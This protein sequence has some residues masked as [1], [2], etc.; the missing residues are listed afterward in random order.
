M[1]AITL[2]ASLSWTRAVKLQPWRRAKIKAKLKTT[3]ALHKGR[4]QMA[5]ELLHP[6]GLCAWPFGVTG[7]GEYFQDE[8]KLKGASHNECCFSCLANKAD[9]SYND[10]KAGAK[11]RTTVVK[12]TGACPPK[13]LISTVPGVVGEYWHYELFHILC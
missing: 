5:G 7:D 11:W 12:H 2:E 4:V 6:D 8:Y 10:F 13:H 9:I 3:K 1:L